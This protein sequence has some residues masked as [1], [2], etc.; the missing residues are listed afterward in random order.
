MFSFFTISIHYVCIKNIAIK[1]TNISGS[2]VKSVQNS[3]YYMCHFSVIFKLF[4]NK[5]LKIH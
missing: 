1:N 4:Q 2:W 3:L 5:T